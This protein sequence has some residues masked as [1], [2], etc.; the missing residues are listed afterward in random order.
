MKLLSTLW[1]C[2]VILAA[3]GGPGDGPG[4]GQTDWQ[5][6]ELEGEVRSVL[7][8]EYLA[9]SDP[10]T[11]T[12]VRGAAIG[13]IELQF[14]RQGYVTELTSYDGDGELVGRTLYQVNR[15]NRRVSAQHYNRAG[16]YEM[17]PVRY[18]YD[19]DGFLVEQVNFDTLGQAVNRIVH[20]NDQQ[21]RAEQISI[22]CNDT[23]VSSQSI[24][25]DK[26]GRVAESVYDMPEYDERSTCRIKYRTDTGSSIDTLIIRHES[27]IQRVETTAMSYR[28]DERGNWVEC[29][30]HRLEQ[31]VY[32]VITRDITYY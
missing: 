6:N 28:Y 17:G 23:L 5:R 25:Y 15:Q 19:E 7:K 22:Y 3:C 12:L 21:G 30:T 11:D 9:Q 16:E 4:S 24:R 20:R 31:N 2:A 10:A 26:L 32:T 29:V 27:P 14:N 8:F 18:R 1:F 13:G